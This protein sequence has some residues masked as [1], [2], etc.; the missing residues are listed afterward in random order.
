LSV[1]IINDNPESQR[2]IGDYLNS[3]RYNIVFSTN[4]KDG[5]NT[6]KQISPAAVILNPFINDKSIWSI[7]VDFKND[8]ETKDIPVILT[9]ILEE[10][11]VGWEPDVFDFVLSSRLL[12][13]SENN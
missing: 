12:R 6:A 8:P 3:Y 1:L 7:I 2:L 9:M 13:V 10:E 11:K 5:F 4:R